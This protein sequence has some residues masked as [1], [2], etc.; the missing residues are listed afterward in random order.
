MDRGCGA[1]MGDSSRTGQNEDTQGMEGLV[2]E[3]DLPGREWGVNT[4][5]AKGGPGVKKS[6]LWGSR[7]RVGEFGKKGCQ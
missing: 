4:I 7:K 3:K 5:H 6:S 2:R 1:R